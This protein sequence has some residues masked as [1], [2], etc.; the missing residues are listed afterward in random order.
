VSSVLVDTSVWRRYFAGG[1][2]VRALGALLDDD[3]IL[4]HPFVVGELLLGGLS[5][6]EEELLGHLP[7]AHVA[8]HAE[9]LRFVKQR[10]LARRGV[11]WVDVH[12]LASALASSAALW[13]LD[14]PLADVARALGV[15]FDAAVPS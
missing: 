5:A 15:A 7:T 12:V 3:A 13:S 9:V 6:R 10:G 4:I 1:A 14:H 11:G 2:N 8:A